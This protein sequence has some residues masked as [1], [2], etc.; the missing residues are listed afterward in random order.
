MNA[1]RQDV[2]VNGRLIMFLHFTFVSCAELIRV[3]TRVYVYAIVFSRFL[4][5]VFL[6]YP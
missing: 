2:P 4:R 3:R 5:L 1:V 6:Q